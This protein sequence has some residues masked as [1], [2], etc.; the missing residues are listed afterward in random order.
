MGPSVRGV[1]A[2][3]LVLAASTPSCGSFNHSCKEAGCV[4]QRT[5]QFSV[6]SLKDGFASGTYVIAVEGG[7]APFRITCQATLSNFVQ[8]SDGTST[9]SPSNGRLDVTVDITDQPKTLTVTVTRD[10]VVLATRAVG[11]SY[12]QNQPNGPDCPP[13]CTT[14]TPST[15]TID[16]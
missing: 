1:G 16:V 6:T 2:L 15:D 7:H 3:L 5:V 9:W 10:G 14:A 11:I 13:T 12:G 4:S 8:C